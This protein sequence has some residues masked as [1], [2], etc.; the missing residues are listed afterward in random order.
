MEKMPEVP[1]VLEAM[2]QKSKELLQMIKN[3]FGENSILALKNKVIK[4]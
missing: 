4:K 1:A 2:P 3:I